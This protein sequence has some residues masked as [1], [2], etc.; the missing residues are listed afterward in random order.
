MAELTRAEVLEKAKDL[1]IEHHKS[2]KTTAVAKMVEDLTGETYELKKNVEPV[3]SGTI[4]CIIHS[5]DRENDEREVRGSLNG[6][7]WRAL[8]GEEIEFPKKFLPCLDGA[9][10]EQRVSVLD[11]AGQ[12]TGKYKDRKHKRYILERV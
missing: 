12:P 6:E 11:E 2:A 8:I 7:T 10:E 3:T 9:V 1:G 4:R 5:N